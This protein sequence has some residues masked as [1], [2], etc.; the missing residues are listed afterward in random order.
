MMLTSYFDEAIAKR[1][2]TGGSEPFT[3]I[4][5]WIAS[6]EQWERYETDWKLFLAAYRIPYLHMKKFAHSKKPF[7]R[8]EGKGTLRAKL[9]N[10]AADIIS[11][12]VKSGFACCVRHEDFR[13]IDRLYEFS[14]AFSSPYG[15]AGR[16]AMLMANN[17]TR[18]KYGKPPEIKYVFEDGD[19]ENIDKGGLIKAVTAITPHLPTPSFEP[20]R[21]RTPSRKWP[22]GRKGLVQLQSSDYLAYES[23]KA[24]Q[25]RIDGRTSRQSDL[26][27]S[28]LALLNIPIDRAIINQTTLVKLCERAG[29][30]KRKMH[31]PLEG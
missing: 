19:G 10:D 6:I 12:N 3:F 4:C 21:D 18:K 1:P 20:S 30:K 9:L 2:L 26:R 16:V 24:L 17:W 15:F 8:F 25:D 29:I 23:R 27:K 22:N 13:I 31:V 14:E 11:N 5:G 7:V 28:N